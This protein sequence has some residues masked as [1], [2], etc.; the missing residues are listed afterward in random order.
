M[1]TATV[2]NLLNQLF[3]FLSDP[4][5]TNIGTYNNF[6]IKCF[7]SS[8]FSGQYGISANTTLFGTSKKPMGDDVI[9]IFL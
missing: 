3:N 4:P 5:N 7:E 1:R 2:S 8:S 9:V 6:S